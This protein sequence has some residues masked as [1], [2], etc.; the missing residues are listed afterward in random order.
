MQQTT[1]NNNVNYSHRSNNKQQ[2]NTNT[3]QSINQHLLANTIAYYW[4][5][6]AMLL[7]AMMSVRIK[8]IEYAKVSIHTCM[9]FYIYIPNVLQIFCCQIVRFHS[10]KWIISFRLHGTCF[11]LMLNER[12]KTKT[13]KK[14]IKID[15]EPKYIYEL[16]HSIYQ[17]VSFVVFDFC[18][19]YLFCYC[20]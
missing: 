13:L 11:N 12:R 17:N 10:A 9:W 16:P 7:T 2:T 15:I 3:I 14:K 4:W 18:H 1:N 19:L 5:W 8:C 20:L 6:Y